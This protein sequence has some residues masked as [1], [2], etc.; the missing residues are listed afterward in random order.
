MSRITRREFLR[1][2]AMTAAGAVVVACAPQTVVVKE[3]VEVEKEKIV[4]K[5]VKVEVT[6]APEASQYQ[7]APMLA[8][9]VS[10]KMLP[11]VDERLPAEPYVAN[12]TELYGWKGDV[13]QYG[14]T[15]RMAT[16]GAGD[17]ALWERTVRSGC[18]MI[19]WD[20]DFAAGKMRPS[21]A[22]S[23]EVSDDGT[24]FTFYMRKGVKFSDGEPF[25]TAN[26]QWWYDNVAS[27]TDVSPTF[28]SQWSIG[29]EPV[30]LDVID[31][32]TFKFTFGLPN[33]F[34]L[35]DLARPGGDGFLVPMHYLQGFHADF[36]KADELEQAV[37]FAEYDD[38]MQLFGDRNNPTTN[39]ELPMLWPWTT[40]VGIGEGPQVVFERNPYY[41]VVDAAGQQVPYMDKAVGKVHADTQTMVLDAISGE[42][43]MQSRF[44]TAQ[45]ASF[46]TI[47]MVQQNAEKGDYYF[48]EQCN[49]DGPSGR[50]IPF[51]LTFGDPIKREIFNNIDFR[52]AMS[53][54]INRQDL[55]ALV[56]RGLAE[57]EGPKWNSPIQDDETDAIWD[58]LSVYDP[59]KANQLLDGMGLD[60]KD[61]SGFRLMS[62]GERLVVV[63]ETVTDWPD[64]ISEL[65]MVVDYW[66]AVGVDATLKT[67]DRPLFQERREA[68][69]CEVAC[70]GSSVGGGGA[71]TVALIVDAREYA[72]VNWES[73][74]GPLWWQYY[75]SNGTQG[76]EPPPEVMQSIE[77]YREI[78]R[79][80]DIDQQCELMKELGRMRAENVWQIETGPIWLPGCMICLVKNNMQN[81]PP[82]MPYSWWYPHPAPTQT[83][84]YYY[85]PPQQL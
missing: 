2:G 70:H 68:N 4:E 11:P 53:Y 33:G 51:N 69:E 66:K 36:V 64:A 3:T 47:A 42:I 13:G 26:I 57:F 46:D 43:D 30:Q 74:W 73:D 61:S 49:P 71:W 50:S 76:E 72:P 81:V 63:V 17:G 14:G 78:K 24:E 35:W 39:S 58:E 15:W 80:V 29:G 5:E 10:K 1:V 23:W 25:S 28:P 44:I 65:E 77:I 6:A 20:P 19:D 40:K 54:A 75:N 21:I 84:L 45:F 37:K 59:D 22:K 38:W 34:F 41:F 82:K 60:K 31:D 62:N 7:E 83:Y 18:K 12:P 8:D 32:F 9:M 79:T 85:D 16:R 52:R 48:I 67:W 56:S 27:N 55:W